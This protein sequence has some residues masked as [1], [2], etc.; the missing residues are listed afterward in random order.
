M[1]SLIWFQLFDTGVIDTCG[2]FAA[3]VID[4]GSNSPLCRWPLV[5][6]TPLVNLSPGVVATHVKFA[7]GVIDTSGAP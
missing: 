2:K 7:T 4:T 3:G 5:L 6:L 1:H